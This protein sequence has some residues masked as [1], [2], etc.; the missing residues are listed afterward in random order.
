MANMRLNKTILILFVL[1]T[2]SA[3]T[4]VVEKE[5]IKSDD[6]FM[7]NKSPESVRV[8]ENGDIKLRY[9]KKEA[10]DQFV[11]DGSIKLMSSKEVQTALN[12]TK[13]EEAPK[14]NAGAEDDVVVNEEVEDNSLLLSYPVNLLG[15]QNIFGGVITKISDKKNEDLGSLKLT[16]LTPL[17]VITGLSRDSSGT[18]L[19]LIGCVSK[20]EEDS[21]QGAIMSFP[22]VG[23]D[24]EKNELIVDLSEA[25]QELNLL[26]MLDP[27][28][29]ETKLK[30]KSSETVALDFSITTLVFDVS[31]KFVPV[32]SEP[33]DETAPV[34]VVV[35]RWYLKLGSGFNPAFVPR[36]PIKEVGF[37]KTERSKEV[38]IMRHAV[39][40]NGKRVHYYVKNVPEKYRPHVKASF[41]GWNAEF[42]TILGRDLLSY[43]F[44][45]DGSPMNEKIVA[46]DIRYNVMEWDLDN[47]ATYGGLGPSIA[48]QYTGEIFSANTLIQGPKI[49][50]MYTKWFE[51]S[52]QAR[53]LIAQNREAEADA[54]LKK[55]VSGIQAE[56]KRARDIRYKVFLGKNKMTVHAQRPEL[57]D[58]IIK[59]LFELV[60]EGMTFDTYMAGYFQEM[61]QHEMGHNLGLRHNFKGNLGSNESKTKGSVSRSIM[62]YLGRGFRYLNAIGLYDRMAIAYGYKNV[63][64]TH[65]DWFCTDEDQ[66]LDAKSI[67]ERSPE[68]SK[69]DA[70]PDPFSFWEKRLNRTI[71]IMVAPETTR[72]PV[73][74][75]AHIKDEVKDVATAF[76]AYALSAEKTAHSWTNFFGKA[77]RPE[78]KADIKAYVVKS[79]TD[80][81]CSPTI[82]EAIA[83]KETS[84]AQK[85]TQDSYDSLVKVMTEQMIKV[86]LLKDKETICK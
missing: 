80:R 69:S 33:T 86:G 47:L 14:A 56:Q 72:A 4:K 8:V 63:A 21:R 57:E 78:N 55:F 43:E 76:S 70:T 75:I 31:S 1:G 17:H 79:L 81:I 46:G 37:F 64:P 61:I 38:R 62:E 83:L 65:A 42:K 45:P 11:K 2:F 73:L 19:T 67:L 25:G 15:E 36:A 29:E 35:T 59:G 58:P 66:G 3:C 16:D 52:G 26:Q 12:Q 13:F 23:M 51:I 34:T 18:Y 39:P 7:T 41:D 5:K 40:N 50:E 60:P 71:E 49:V 9:L 22:I 30:A 48:N 44:I 82:I 32:S 85:A 28:G 24:V 6:N 54:L 84:E 27:K 53:A 77:D 10:F 68:C 74:T 20:C